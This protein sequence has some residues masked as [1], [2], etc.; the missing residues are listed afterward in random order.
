MQLM[1]K[2]LG[3][4]ILLLVA[5]SGCSMLTSWKAIPPPG[6]CGQCHQQPIASNWEVV[7]LPPDLTA[8]DS[9]YKWQRSTS[10]LPEEPSPL[11]EQK[12]SE[13]RCFR[14]HNSPDKAHKD[15]RGSYHH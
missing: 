3:F 12:I 5:G 15:Y 13:Q 14:C 2:F 9:R 1:A 11:E 7:Y 8:E 6:G 4:I 10:M